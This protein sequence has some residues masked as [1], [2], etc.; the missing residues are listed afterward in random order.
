MYLRSRLSLAHKWLKF[1]LSIFKMKIGTQIAL[2][3]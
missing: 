2:D 3:V 1:Y